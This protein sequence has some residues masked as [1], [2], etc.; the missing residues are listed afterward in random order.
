ME[1]SKL[2]DLFC[3]MA[4]LILGKNF[5]KNIRI[6]YALNGQ[7]S[8]K[9]TEDIIFIRLFEKDD[10]YAKQ[11]N[12]SYE[13]SGNV[14]KKSSRTRVWEVQ[15]VAYGPSAN[16]NI[17]KIKDGVFRQEVKNLL[18][19]D[20]VFFVPNYPQSKRVPELFSGQWWNRWDLSLNFNELYKLP[21]EDV[22]RIDSVEITGH[23][24]R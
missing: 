8:W 7:P 19:K 14:I 1:F 6:S 17:N 12:S 11:I 2:E 5:T 9:S 13:T 10:E 18:A 15:I 16:E 23:Y 21:D 20:N 3:D 24:N 22:G 4:E